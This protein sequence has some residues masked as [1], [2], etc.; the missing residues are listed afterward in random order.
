MKHPVT[1]SFALVLVALPAGAHA[2]QKDATGCQDHALFTRMP[3]Y[4]IRDCGNTDFDAYAFF[5]GQGKTE[6]FGGKVAR[7]T[8]LT[9]GTLRNKPSALQVLRNYENAAK[10]VGGTVVAS[11]ADRETLRIAKDG[12]EFRVEV[13]YMI[14]AGT[15]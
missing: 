2:Q 8:Y 14:V 3:G 13:G 11:N 10:A 9:L 4:W 1:L 7:L 15:A 6:R 12:K 5:A